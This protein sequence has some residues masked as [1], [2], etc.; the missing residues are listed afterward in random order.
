[1]TGDL[2]FGGGGGIVNMPTN[3]IAITA[4]LD[5]DSSGFFAQ[6]TGISNV[7]ANT[8]VTIQANTGGAVTSVWTFNS[9]G[10]LT[11]PDSTIQSTAFTGSAIDQASRN[12][13]N[14]AN[15]LAQNAYNFANTLSIITANSLIFV[16]SLPA[17][18]KGLLGDKKGYVYLAN[19]YFYYCTT[20]YDG[21][22]NIW[23][24]IA[25]TDAW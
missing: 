13:A 1:M 7:Y 9:T 5:I 14:S 15:V 16:S 4:N 25:S 23:S 8:D 3:Q 20:N 6:A 22:T 2:K 24:R 12:T 19:N 11:F 18:N 10:S 17:T 21:S